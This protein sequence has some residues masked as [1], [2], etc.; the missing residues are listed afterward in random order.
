MKNTADLSPKIGAHNKGCLQKQGSNS[1]A[2]EN[3]HDA[4]VTKNGERRAGTVPEATPRKVLYRIPPKTNAKKKS[5]CS[6]H[7]SCDCL[8]KK[9]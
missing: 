2:Y 6:Q 9:K 1:S 4:Q 5:N 8:E 7:L 3:N